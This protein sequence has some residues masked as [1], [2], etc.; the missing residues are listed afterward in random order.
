MNIEH[1]H[2]SLVPLLGLSA[3]GVMEEEENYKVG[4][5]MEYVVLLHKC[6]IAHPEMLQD[7]QGVGCKKNAQNINDK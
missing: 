2:S 6:R 3:L 4:G 7:T 1:F 5:R